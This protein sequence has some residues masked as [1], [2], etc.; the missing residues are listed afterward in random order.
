LADAYH[1]PVLLE[2]VLD[3]LS[4]RAGGVYV[5]ATA[6]GGGHSRGIADRIGSSGVVIGIDRDTEALAEAT[7][8]LIGSPAR[9]LSFCAPFDE[10]VEI[11]AALGYPEV[12][13][14]LYDLGVSSRQLDD[15]KRGFTFRDANAP[16]DMRMSQ[17]EETPT[18]ADILNSW[19]AA[20]LT[21]ILRE[22]AD[23]RW[24]SRIAAFIVDRRKGAPFITAEQLIDVV[25][26]AVP[27][28][29]RS[30]DIHP[31]T[32][33]F[34]ALRIAVND[35]F[36]RL[37]RSLVGAVQSLT[38]GGHIA[39]ISYHSG[40][41]RIVKQTFSELAGKCVCPPEQPTC[42]CRAR[43]P[44][45]EIVTKKPITPTSQEIATNPRAR[46]AKLRIVRKRL[47]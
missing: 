40:E 5:D 38:A 26:A 34:Q 43:M 4:L 2:E 33:A 6:G 1:R 10:I 39:A 25:K 27:A 15:P 32:K 8:T 11:L 36:G 19:T 18:A 3:G 20:E 23:E 16:L 31:A 41:D 47:I 24:A 12:D 28:A 9:F 44:L 45:I 46:S 42:V 29:A 17:T 13:G 21:E 35:E 14:V 30:K 22:N 37:R 7:A